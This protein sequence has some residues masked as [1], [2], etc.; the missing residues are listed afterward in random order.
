MA[1]A[2]EPSSDAA[3][4]K[5]EGISTDLDSQTQDDNG[6]KSDGSNYRKPAEHMTTRLKVKIFVIDSLTSALL[7]SG[8]NF[9]I[10]YGTCHPSARFAHALII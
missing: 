7:G 2:T 9:G 5:E 3:Q 4:I 8:I 10:A 1:V 6:A